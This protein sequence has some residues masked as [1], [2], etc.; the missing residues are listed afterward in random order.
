MMCFNIQRTLTHTVN[1]K[2]LTQ[3]VYIVRSAMKEHSVR[4]SYA[5]RWISSDTRENESPILKDLRPLNKSFYCVQLY[6]GQLVGCYSM[7]MFIWKKSCKLVRQFIQGFMYC[8]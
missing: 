8:N 1:T 2:A 3:L 6:I 7:N 4:F 5:E